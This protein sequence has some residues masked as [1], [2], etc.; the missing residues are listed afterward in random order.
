[1][2]PFVPNAEIKDQG[3]HRRAANARLIK[4]LDAARFKEKLLSLLLAAE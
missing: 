4:K 1:M 3:F 2:I